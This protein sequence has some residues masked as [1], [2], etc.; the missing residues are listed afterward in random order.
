MAIILDST[1]LPLHM[2]L[3]SAEMADHLDKNHRKRVVHHKKPHTTP[4]T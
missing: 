4:K 1:E 2:A 3:E